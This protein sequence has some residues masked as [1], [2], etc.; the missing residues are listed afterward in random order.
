MN[1]FG[2]KKIEKDKLRSTAKGV[3]TALKKDASP[4]A[5]VSIIENSGFTVDEFMD[6]LQV[7]A[8]MEVLVGAEYKWNNLFKLM[9]QKL[10]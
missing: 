10:S 5:V 2:V 6:G 3:E 8:H 1:L 4:K 9:H 7:F